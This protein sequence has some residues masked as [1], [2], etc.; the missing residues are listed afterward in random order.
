MNCWAKYTFMYNDATHS[1]DKILNVFDTETGQ[2]CKDE[3]G[4]LKIREVVDWPVSGRLLRRGEYKRFFNWA[5][6]FNNYH[7]DITDQEYT[8]S[9]G[10]HPIRYRTKVYEGQVNNLR[11][12]NQEEKEFL[13]GFRQLSMLPEFFKPK[14]VFS[15]MKNDQAEKE[16]VTKL[17]SFRIVE[18]NIR[19]ADAST[20]QALIPYVKR[21]L[22]LF[23]KIKENVNYASSPHEV[24]KRVY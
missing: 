23:P 3:E 18:G 7:P 20:L 22:Q 24:R 11:I 21:L 2:V 6:H 1:M 5:Q 4:Q 8:R 12:F 17:Q 13:Q 15:L 14:E 16:A 10:Y 9:L 19:C